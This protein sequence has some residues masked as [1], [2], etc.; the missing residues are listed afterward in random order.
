MAQQLATNDS[1][2]L[3]SPDPLPHTMEQQVEGGE[4]G[5][6]STSLSSNMISQPSVEA[7]LPSPIRSSTLMQ[8]GNEDGR[9]PPSLSGSQNSDMV[10]QHDEREVVS[11]A[12]LNSP[13]VEVENTP[14]FFSGP[15]YPG[16]EE[17][18]EHSPS[19]P[20]T[21]GELTPSTE[22]SVQEGS[23]SNILAQQAGIQ[24][25]RSFSLSDP[26]QSSIMLRRNANAESASANRNFSS[27]MSVQNVNPQRLRKLIGTLGLDDQRS[28]LLYKIVTV[29]APFHNTESRLTPPG[30]EENNPKADALRE[31]VGSLTFAPDSSTAAN[32]EDDSVAGSTT[33]NPTGNLLFDANASENLGSRPIEPQA[34]SPPLLW[35]TAMVEESLDPN[36][37]DPT[38]YTVAEFVNTIIEKGI[39]VESVTEDDWAI[40]ELRVAILNRLKEEDPVAE[41]DSSEGDS[42]EGVTTTTK[43]PEQAKAKKDAGEPDLT[44]E[45]ELKEKVVIMEEATEHMK[46]KEDTSESKSAVQ[47][48]DLKTP[49]VIEEEAIKPVET[50]DPI[51]SNLQRWK[52][53]GP[54]GW[55]KRDDGTDMNEEEI[56]AECAQWDAMV[57]RARHEKELGRAAT[58]LGTSV[59]LEDKGF[60]DYVRS[61]KQ[62]GQTTASVSTHD[63][64]PAA[65]ASTHDLDEEASQKK[66]K[67]GSRKN[68]NKNR[69][70]KKKALRRAELEAESDEVCETEFFPYFLDLPTQARN[71]VL[72]FILVVNHDLMPYHYIKDA[73]V[74]NVGLVEKPELNV[75]IALCSSKDQKVKKCLDDAK[76][77][78]YRDNIF[79]IR[80]PTDFIMF[81]GTIGGDNLARLKM[82]KNLLLTDSFFDKNH[83]SELEMKWLARWG[84]DLLS[85][86]DGLNDFRSDILT[87]SSEN[88]LTCEPRGMEKALKTMVEVMKNEGKMGDTLKENSD[89]SSPVRLRSLDLGE[90]FDSLAEHIKTM[91]LDAGD[92]TATMPDTA[93]LPKPDAP[94]E[95][96]E[97]LAQNWTQKALNAGKVPDDEGGT[98]DYGEFFLETVTSLVGE[99][100]EEALSQDSGLYT[101][102]VYSEQGKKPSF[103]A[104]FSIDMIRQD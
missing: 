57:R 95:A 4:H 100:E 72:G 74:T 38:H 64:N 102:S 26:A 7:L 31:T 104:K 69:K 82:G 54:D 41:E 48:G 56:D 5:T 59:D 18:H 70:A 99:K 16:T 43:A 79:S 12:I 34:D 17:Q 22:H 50:K 15:M 27:E 80:N 101:P 8:I 36:A 51:T 60:W 45:G 29:T 52:E 25:H 58:S 46:A 90:R 93:K 92:S 62:K 37:E 11:R 20:S 77:I 85:T 86:I 47:G 103:T 63:Q 76:N 40:E 33:D 84:K 81:L 13:R 96:V 73:V 61:S 44:V 19:L 67:K 2:P 21:L 23:D 1:T 71:K 89:G 9:M 3:S 83:Q 28:E 65:S 55:L 6:N 68:K 14:P 88:D 97:S 91:G 78:L 39:Q 42:N 24:Q 10:Q 87:K 32:A 49:V 53:Q 94:E 98:K 35:S 30:P 75:L 66:N